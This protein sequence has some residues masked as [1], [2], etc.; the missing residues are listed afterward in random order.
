[1]KITATDVAAKVTKVKLDMVSLK[2]G[3][4]TARRT[5]FYTHGKTAQILVN[6]ITDAF[7]T[8]E[9]LESGEIWKPFRGGAPVAK[10]SHWFVKFTIR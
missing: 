5:F 6:A 2:H 7:P 1:M 4:F 10:Q 8:A 3:V 9:I